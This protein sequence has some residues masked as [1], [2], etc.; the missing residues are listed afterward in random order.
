MK[1]RV[2]LIHN[3]DVGSNAGLPG[4]SIPAGLTRSGLPV[5]LGLDAVGR[6]DAYLLGIALTLDGL[7]PAPQPQLMSRS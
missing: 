4:V 1:G 6:R 7:F 3:T 5:G 2:V